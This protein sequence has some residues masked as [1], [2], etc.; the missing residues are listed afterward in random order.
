[1]D[2]CHPTTLSPMSTTDIQ[3]RAIPPKRAL[4]Q[5]QE[6]YDASDEDASD[7]TEGDP[8]A[9]HSQPLRPIPRPK[10]PKGTH[11]ASHLREVVD[12][13]TGTDSPTYDGDIESST[14][15]LKQAVHHRSLLS[16]SSTDAD[17]SPTSTPVLTPL[18]SS[19]TLHDHLNVP[20]ATTTTTTAPSSP[21][22]T[23]HLPFDPAV[24]TPADIQSFVQ[25]AI[26]GEAHRKYKINKPPTGR[27][28]RVY[29]DGTHCH[30]IP[31]SSC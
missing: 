1:M 28:I 4:I 3:A 31:C 13:D 23:A 29:A 6:S 9:T 10:Q 26:D 22:P 25:K 17:G 27:P 18:A 30:Y 21:K 12:S 14:N 15:T 19:A 8:L 7:R 24:L 11:H 16:I 5:N 2:F 20:G